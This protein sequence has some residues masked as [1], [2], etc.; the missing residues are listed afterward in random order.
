[1]LQALSGARY[2]AIDQVMYIKGG[3]GDFTSFISTATGFG[4]VGIREGKPF[5]DVAYGE[6]TVK[7]FILNK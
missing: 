6:I 3:S 1:M 2:D 5:L 4:N 7:D